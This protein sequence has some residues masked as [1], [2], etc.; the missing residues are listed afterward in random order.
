M[1]P[2]GVQSSEVEC[3]P[4]GAGMRL[5]GAL[6]AGEGAPPKRAH[7]RWL[8][9][10]SRDLRSRDRAERTVKEY[11][12]DV[13][14]FARWFAK[15]WG[16]VMRP[17]LVTALDLR[18]WK[19]EM[20]QRG[21]KPSTL[22]RRLAALRCFFA[23]AKGER[24][25]LSDPTEG[26]REK[27]SVPQTPR[28]LTRT[29]VRRLR[30]AADA[31]ILLADQ[32]RPP[33]KMTAT[34]REARRDRAMLILLL[35]TGVRTSELCAL[36]LRD[37]VLSRRTGTLTVRSGKGNKTR[38]IPLNGD[39]R[40]AL[41]SWLEVRPDVSNDHLFVGR[42][43]EP[44]GATTLQHIIQSLATRAGLPSKLTPHILRHT[45]AKTLVDL[46]EP[47][48]RVQVLLGHDSIVT[49]SRYTRPDESDLAA[50]VERL[51]WG[52]PMPAGTDGN[53]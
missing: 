26:I 35:S 39:A 22:N 5:D 8:E 24:L 3:T 27:R 20:D 50:T 4:S 25:V 38:T 30:E 10:F 16:Q 31:R 21:W 49:T 11:C 12:D 15:R 19:S 2:A 45:F 43:G 44:L 37:L 9:D 41:S 14:A 48:T 23:W 6:L 33:I 18:E 52:E 47:L 46:G 34:A 36:C 40:S 7:A 53:G 51:S 1:K 17:E 29:E 13:A 28:S 32:K 42:R